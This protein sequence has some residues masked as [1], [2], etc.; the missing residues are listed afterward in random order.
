MRASALKADHMLPV[1]SAWLSVP[2]LLLSARFVLPSLVTDVAIVRF[3][4]HYL[5]CNLMITALGTEDMSR[6]R[7]AHACTCVQEANDIQAC[8]GKTSC[9]VDHLTRYRQPG[10]SQLRMPTR[11]R[12]DHVTT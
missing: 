3:L 1:P 12:I 6:L 4:S 11:Q 9:S 5:A 7:I 8:A 2:I 10:Y